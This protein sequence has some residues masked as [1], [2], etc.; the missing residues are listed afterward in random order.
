MDIHRLYGGKGGGG[1][2]QHQSSRAVCGFYSTLTTENK[3]QEGAE[4]VGA[5][6]L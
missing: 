2:S 5:R 1:D 4:N 6:Y 3:I